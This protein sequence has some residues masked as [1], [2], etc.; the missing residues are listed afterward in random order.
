LSD[1][2]AVCSDELA[3]SF[4]LLEKLTDT[5]VP[6][7]TPMKGIDDEL[8]SIRANL[9]QALAAKTSDE[10]ET[11]HALQEQ[12]DAIDAARLASGGVFCGRLAAGEVPSGQAAASALLAECYSL[13]QKIHAQAREA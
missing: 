4:E 11:V 7:S 3:A 12:L 9:R 6:I 1:G 5:A 8:Y 13:V 2:Q 10:T